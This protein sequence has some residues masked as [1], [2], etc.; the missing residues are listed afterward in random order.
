M[1]REESPLQWPGALVCVRDATQGIC[2]QTSQQTRL[3]NGELIDIA[4]FARAE[5]NAPVLMDAIFRRA[6]DGPAAPVLAEPV[7]A[8]QVLL[9]KHES[10]LIQIDGQLVSR[11][12]ASADTTLLL[13]SGKRGFTAILPEGLGGPETTAWENGSVLRITGICSVQIDAQRTGVGL[14]EIPPKTFRVLMRSPV[15]VVVIKR[16]SWWTPAHMVVLLAL[17]LCGTLVVLAWVVVLRRRIHESEERFRHMAQHDTL[18]GLAT[19]LVLEDQLN[20]ALESARRLQT[21]LALLMLDID[22]FKLINDSLGHHAGDK[23]LRVTANRMV[24]AVRKS[25]TVAR[26]GGDEFIVLLP[27]LNDSEMVAGFAAK[28]VTALSMPVAFAG[29]EVSVTVSVGVCA[30]EAGRMDADTM[31]KNVDAALYRA[32][33]QGRNRFVVFTPE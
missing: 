24:E 8:E 30:S 13:T 27:D 22:R 3:V 5:G 14:A 19:R 28:I 32:K 15:D 18:T 12:P 25:D 29:R 1:C 2:A 6:E 16:A 33:A 10:Q 7:I 26:M 11:D 21:G 17:A 9:G 20:V 4:G 23:V 31:L